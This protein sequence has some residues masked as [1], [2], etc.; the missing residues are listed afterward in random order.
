MNTKRQ[1]IQTSRVLMGSSSRFHRRSI[2]RL[3]RKTLVETPEEARA[4]GIK[5]AKES[6]QKL[7]LHLTA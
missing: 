3:F 5:M 6:A 4:L 2:L 1:N 7:K